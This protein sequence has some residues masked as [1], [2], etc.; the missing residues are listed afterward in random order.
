M[1]DVIIGKLKGNLIQ[2]GEGIRHIK[3]QR[4]QAAQSEGI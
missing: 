3:S 1:T 2:N 4:C